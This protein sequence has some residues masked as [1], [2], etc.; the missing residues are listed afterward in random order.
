MPLT[1]KL[2]PLKSAIVPHLRKYN[3]LCGNEEGNIPPRSMHAVKHPYFKWIMSSVHKT[4]LVEV[5]RGTTYVS[6]SIM[7]GGFD[8]QMTGFFPLNVIKALLKEA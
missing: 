1:F 2:G 4:L 6:I 8:I 3:A 7:V 5:F